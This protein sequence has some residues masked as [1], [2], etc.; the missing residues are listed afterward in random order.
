MGGKTDLL[1][2]LSGLGEVLLA[3]I[4]DH[5]L[6]AIKCF[7]SNCCHPRVCGKIVE[8]SRGLVGEEIPSCQETAAAGIVFFFITTYMLVP[9]G[10]KG[11]K[12]V[13]GKV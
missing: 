5:L 3:S 7:G 6:L 12:S 10:R 4:P 1:S 9:G 8:D 11:V 2:S 13:Q